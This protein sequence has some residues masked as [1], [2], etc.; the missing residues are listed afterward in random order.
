MIVLVEIIGQLSVNIGF[1]QDTNPGLL[2]ESL[3]FVL[4]IHHKVCMH[5]V[6]SL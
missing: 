2:S 6:G 5:S 4:F 3:P 1:S